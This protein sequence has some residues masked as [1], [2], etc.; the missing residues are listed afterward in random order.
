MSIDK[1]YCYEP[2]VLCIVG[3]SSI[4]RTKGVI[5]LLKAIFEV[6]Q[7]YK[8]ISG[9]CVGIDTIAEEVATMYVDDMEIYEPRVR[10]WHD[11]FKPR[12]LR[13]AQDCT[14]MYVIRDVN[15]NSYGSGWTSD[16]AEK[17]GKPVIRYY[18]KYEEEE[19]DY[20]FSL[21]KKW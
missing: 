8:F 17:L 6:E 13:M 18:A 21:T 11:G 16:K 1:R 20:V 9:G 7:P 19:K 4:K 2:S 5:K 15:S 3:S 10:N 12:N 14:I